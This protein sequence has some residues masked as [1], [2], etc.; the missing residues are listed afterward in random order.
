[1]FS[2]AMHIPDGF[3]SIPVS[4][5]G[6]A[7][8]IITLG[9][10]LQQTRKR[11]G[12]RQIPLMGILAACIFAA[13]MLNFPVAG[14]TSGHVLGATL[15]AILI[16]PW[17]AVLVMTCVI[18]TQGLLFQDGGLLA[19]GFNVFN[20]GIVSGFVGYATYNLVRKA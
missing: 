2:P 4:I 18:G 9:F 3:L 13:Q 14:G 12:E 5:I 15:V 17:A 10:A 7:L 11:L 6:W 19:L 1:M 20:M 8:L 16:D